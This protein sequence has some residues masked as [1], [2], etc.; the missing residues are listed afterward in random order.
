MPHY[1][2]TTSK[3]IILT[4]P[5]KFIINSGSPVTLIPECLSSKLTPIET[6]KVTYKDVNNQK[7]NF[8]G[9]TKAT[10]KTNKET[11]ELP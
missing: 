10:V 8:V 3:F 6:L 2:L 9:Q 11:I 7:I 5:I 1:W 4:T